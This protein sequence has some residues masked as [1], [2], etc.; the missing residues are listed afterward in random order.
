VDP[1]PDR[2]VVVNDLECLSLCANLLQDYVALIPVVGE[3][4]E[5]QGEEGRVLARVQSAETQPACCF[6]ASGSTSG[7]HK[8]SAPSSVS[9]LALALFIGLRPAARAAAA[10][11]AASPQRKGGGAAAAARPRATV[12]RAGGGEG[13]EGG[14]PRAGSGRWS[15]AVMKKRILACASCELIKGVPCD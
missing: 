2:L 1:Q 4:G 13:G 10:S 5:A 9:H 15:R 8:H 7:E 3:Q 6:T 12:L 11:L 14:L